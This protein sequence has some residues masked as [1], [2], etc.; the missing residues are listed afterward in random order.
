MDTSTLSSNWKILQKRL[1]AGKKAAPQSSSKSLKRKRS[2]MSNQTP[3]QSRLRSKSTATPKSNA[4]STSPND[5]NPRPS[6]SHS[7]H[8]ESKALRNEGVSPTAFPGKYIAL[9]CEFV[10]VGPPP[11]S[12]NQLARV[13]LVN[14]HGEQVYDTFVLPALPVADY[15]T[16]VSGVRKEDLEE[17]RKFDEV[18]EDVA[19]FL[20]GRVLVGHWLKSDLDV[21]MLNHPRH[22]VRDT[23][24]LEKFRTLMGGNVKL[25]DVAKKVL[26]LEIQ[27]G[28][29]DS[30]E[31]A[32]TAMLLF[33]AERD[34]FEG[35]KKTKTPN[36]FTKADAK[37]DEERNNIKKKKRRK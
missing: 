17:G 8:P 26:G 9:D 22:M 21:L 10:G 2:H 25:K 34:E 24:W 14:Y 16:F 23:A 1:S 27:K 36:A 32:R 11:H 18:R 19:L 15:R 31:D 3:I 7:G 33:R 35:E 4:L 13:S 37:L 6:T 12:D 20:K 5:S 30:V 29:H 28:E